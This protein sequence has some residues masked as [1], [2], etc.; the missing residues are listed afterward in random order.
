M[1]HQ[2]DPAMPPGAN[3]ESAFNT[4]LDALFSGPPGTM[5]PDDSPEASAAREMRT[6]AARTDASFAS[7]SS[8]KEILMASQPPTASLA[9]VPIRVTRPH[10]RIVGTMNRIVSIAAILAIVLAGVATAWVSRDRL[11]FGDD[12][13]PAYSLVASPTSEVTCTTHTL[14]QEAVNRIAAEHRAPTLAD[15]TLSDAPVPAADALAAY[16]TYR[17]LLSCPSTTTDDDGQIAI[18]TLVTDRYAIGSGSPSTNASLAEFYRT[19]RSLVEP[20]S[21]LLVPP[22]A[23]SYVFDID[24][25]AIAAYM[26]ELPSSSGSGAAIALL[27]SSFVQFTDG[28]IGAPLLSARPGGLRADGNYSQYRVGFFIFAK[29]DGTWLLDDTITLCPEDCTSLERF[30]DLK[31]NQCEALATAEATIAAGGRSSEVSPEAS[32]EPSPA[33]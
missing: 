7:S 18:S 1:P 28:R 13:P 6:L 8:W 32:P 33:T 19:A 2:N 12:N 26:V 10:S 22:P 15:Y 24:D 3:R 4:W 16:E 27:P 20:V 21:R 9:P 30:Y 25:P 5:P 11:G 29:V 17:T 14:S 23:S 31:I